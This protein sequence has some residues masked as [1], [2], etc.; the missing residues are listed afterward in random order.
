MS[1]N[2]PVG[3]GDGTPAGVAAA[4]ERGLRGGGGIANAGAGATGGLSACVPLDAGGANGA[5]ASG[6]ADGGAHM[7]GGGGADGMLPTRPPGT[8]NKRPQSG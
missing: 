1:S 4:G 8:A 6:P 3:G 5:P 2:N 7:P